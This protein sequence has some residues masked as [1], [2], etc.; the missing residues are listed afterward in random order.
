MTLFALF[1]L[2]LATWR[3][4]VHLVFEIR[5]HR[6]R[7]RRGGRG[8]IESG[9]S[10]ITCPNCGAKN[11]VDEPRAARFQAVCGKCG[12]KLPPPAAAGAASAHP[13]TVTDTSLTAE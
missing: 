12:Q 9:M 2:T 13:L 11:R 8:G 1:P 3:L 5:T 10:V 4:G 7:S 6:S